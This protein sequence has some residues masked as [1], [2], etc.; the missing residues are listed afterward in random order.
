MVE[1]I[2]METQF[3]EAQSL[4]PESALKG[5]SKTVAFEYPGDYLKPWVMKDGRATTIRSIRPE[6]EPLMV[7]F[8]ASLSERTIYLRYFYYFKLNKRTSHERLARICS[9]DAERE[10][11]LVVELVSSSLSKGGKKRVAKNKIIA[12]GRLNRI[13]DSNDA[14]IAVL[15]CDQYQGCGLGTELL[16]RLRHI[17]C[18]AKLNR[19]IAEILPENAVMK[20]INKTLD[21]PV[22]HVFEDGLVKAIFTFN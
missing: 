14:E 11:V 19:V 12:V 18:Q 9:I 20:R 16:N 21:F 10:M 8:H 5:V 13:R 6:D 22:T 3:V 17:G 15:I 1:Q 7:E 2:K 4:R